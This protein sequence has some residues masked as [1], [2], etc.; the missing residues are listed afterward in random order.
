MITYVWV[1]KLFFYHTHMNTHTVNFDKLNI[2]LLKTL[3]GSYWCF[4]VNKS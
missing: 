3:H 4:P 1:Y 2:K